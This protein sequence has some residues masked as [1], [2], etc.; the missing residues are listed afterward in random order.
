MHSYGVEYSLSLPLSVAYSVVHFPPFPSYFLFLFPLNL[1][2]Y[3]QLSLLFNWHTCHPTIPIPSPIPIS[4]VP[5]QVKIVPKSSTVQVST[6]RHQEKSTW[7]TLLQ[8]PLFPVSL[9]LTDKDLE[10]LENLENLEDPEDPPKKDL[11][12]LKAL[13]R[14]T[15]STNLS[16]RMPAY[17]S[18]SPSR[19]TAHSVDSIR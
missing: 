16:T 1:S 4:V 8:H 2:Y 11:K 19:E 13:I 14:S 3:T 10:N 15:A 6:L 17:P 9:S 5:V 18:G 12:A 7:N